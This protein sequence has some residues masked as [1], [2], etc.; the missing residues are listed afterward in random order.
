LTLTTVLVQPGIEVETSL[1]TAEAVVAEHDEEC[2]VVGSLH[3][4]T[5]DSI[6]ISI[7]VLDDS[8]EPVLR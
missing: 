2:L 4:A 5:H 1:K 3:G 6:T 8:L 7:V